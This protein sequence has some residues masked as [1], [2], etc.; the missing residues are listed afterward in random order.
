MTSLMVCP[1]TVPMYYDKDSRPVENAAKTR[2]VYLP[3]GTG[4]YDFW[5]EEYYE[6]GQVI[7]AEAPIDIIPVYVKTGSIIP[8]TCSMQYVDEIPDAP[9]EVCVYP[10]KDAVYELYEDEG[11]SYRYEKGEYSLTKM[12]WSE[13][14]R[15]LKI[16]EPSGSYPRMVKIRTFHVKVIS[17]R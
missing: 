2:K 17:E 1:I 5:T 11:N 14:S 16:S 15:E 9:I 7:T 8:M 6:G 3:E 10:G 4:W 12:T 13:E